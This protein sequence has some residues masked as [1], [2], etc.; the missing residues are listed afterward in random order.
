MG[1]VSVAPVQTAGKDTM[2]V[3]FS[4]QYIFMESTVAK[5]FSVPN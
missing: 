4:Y 2:L 5:D 1:S 3:P